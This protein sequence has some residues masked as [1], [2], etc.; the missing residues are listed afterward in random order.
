[1]RE[2]VGTPREDIALRLVLKEG[3]N[4]DLFGEVSISIISVLIMKCC[5]NCV[6]W[7]LVYG[8]V[9]LPER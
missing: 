2:G 3:K 1:L 6:C 9:P 7:I 4:C 5:C 8:N